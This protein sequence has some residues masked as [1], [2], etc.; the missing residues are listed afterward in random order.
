MSM[1]H[2][3]GWYGQEWENL[4]LARNKSSNM[5]ILCSSSGLGC[6][7]DPYAKVGTNQGNMLTVKNSSKA[8]VY[9]PNHCMIYYFLS[10]VKTA[11]NCC[12]LDIQ[13][14]REKEM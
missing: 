7:V 12:L 14:G 13:F 6:W 3:K 2:T 9:G 1:S 11:F 5:A 8:L 4:N 10:S